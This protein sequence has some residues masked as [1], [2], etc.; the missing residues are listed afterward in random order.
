MCKK[1][2]LKIEEKKVQGRREFLLTSAAAGGAAL[3]SRL[4]PSVLAAG[5]GSP[6]K[7]PGQIM[8]YGATEKA[9]SIKPIPIKRRK[10]QKND[11]EIDILYA[12][13]CH[14]D[15]HTVAE[16]WGSNT[17]PVVP[18][19]EIIGKVISTGPN[20]K[21]YKKGD[22]VGVGC[23][24]DSCGTCV[25]C[26]DDR[27]QNCLNGTTFTYGAE[28]KISGGTTYGGYSQS[29]VVNED[30]AVS[31][32]KG[33]DISRAAPIMC[34]GI[35]TFSPMQHWDLQEDQQ[36][37]VIGIGG[38]GHM[39][40]KI[41]KAKG[42]KVTAFTTSKNKFEDIKKMGATPVLWTDEEAFKKLTG[43][44]DLMIATVPESFEVQNFMNL[45]KLDSTLV[46]VG[47]LTSVDGLSG[48]LMAFGRKSLAGSMIGGMKETQE[49]VNFCA[50]HD[51]LPD[52]EIIKPN[53]IND[54]YKRVKDK[55]IKFRFVIDMKA[56]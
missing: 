2:D 40:V 13:I 10:P 32:P 43:S 36:I 39:A 16:D 25:N 30:F 37:G 21:R 15:I 4:V 11:V 1:C 44:F 28:D 29:I 42:A 31:I 38:L 54:A 18:G 20:A 26:K 23:M 8:A 52:V 19:H 24:V 53:Q 49:V 17:Y 22:I 56:S 6:K 50:K 45:L 51:I 7:L 41:A 48:M 9:G 35:T 47:Q 33:I 55:D 3:M 46:N 34:A 14:S 12:G 27:E 5:A